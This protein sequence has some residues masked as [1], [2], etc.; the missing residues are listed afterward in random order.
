M[1]GADPVN[2]RPGF[3]EMFER[4]L[5]NG[6]RTILVESPDRFARDLMMQL[7]G[8]DMLKAKGITLI[9]ASAP[10]FFVKDTPTAVLV[11]QVLRAVAQFE[12][13]T[14]VA[15]LAA[16][17]KRKRIAT[18][19]CEGRKSLAETNPDI[20][21][22][23]KRLARRKPKGGKMSLRA[24]SAELAAQGH[25]NERGKPFNPKSVAVMLARTCAI[26]ALL[27]CILPWVP[28]AFAM[29]YRLAGDKL[30]ASGEIVGGDAQRL[31]RSMALAPKDATTDV[32][33]VTVVLDSLG[34]DLFEGM[35]IGEAIRA[36][37][38]PTLVQ[39]GH[40]CASACALAFLG[41]MTKGVASDAVWRSIE[42]GAELA[43]H[44][45]RFSDNAV[46][47]E[48]ETLDVGRVVNAIVLEFARRMGDVDLGEMA[49]LLDVAPE[50]IEVINTPKEISSLGIRLSGDPPKPP[51]GWAVNACRSAVATKLSPLDVMGLEGRV[52]G[53]SE[54]MKNLAAFRQ[55]ILDDKYP[56]DARTKA[57]RAAAMA[58]PANDAIDLL[59]GEALY[60]DMGKVG[61]WRV[62]LER[63]ASFYFDACYAITDF[64]SIR[65]VLIDSVSPA[66]IVST[67]TTL[68][69]FAADSPLW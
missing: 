51:K 66:S 61:A 54:P 22:L 34:G 56:V 52:P 30:F 13:A 46:H 36:A 58:L 39:R 69:G 26:A 25:L 17:R 60:A 3:A 55:R 2:D 27:L 33:N 48:N 6:A 14:T 1:S 32:P 57:I 24:V 37:G 38:V 5:S 4:L 53:E 8:H 16:A 63:G 47:L 68:S 65:T 45:F 41:G 10:T 67:S 21:A 44:G 28:P 12:K 23:A 20:V 35:R 9:A 59:A 15:K 62:R 50:K 19:K 29:D 49:R 64:Q 11:R 40:T 18:G 42:P 43:F 7:A 31:A